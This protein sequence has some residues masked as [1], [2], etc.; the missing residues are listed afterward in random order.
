MSL[1]ILRGAVP[2]IRVC[3]IPFTNLPDLSPYSDGSHLTLSLILR[4]ISPCRIMTCGLTMMRIAMDRLIPRKIEKSIQ[5]PLPINVV[6]A[7]VMKTPVLRTGIGIA[8]TI[9]RP[10]RDRGSKQGGRIVGVLFSISFCARADDICTQ[11][12]TPN[13]HS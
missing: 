2:T 9:M 4:Q 6:I 8:S 5:D 13:K 11:V 10:R 7:T 1:R 3:T 12:L